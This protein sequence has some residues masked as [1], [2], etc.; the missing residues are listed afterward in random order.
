MVKLALGNVR[1]GSFSVALGARADV[2]FYPERDRNSD[3]L[4]G[5]YVPLTSFRLHQLTRCERVIRPSQTG[6]TPRRWRRSL[7]SIA[8]RGRWAPAASFAIDVVFAN[9]PSRIG[10]DYCLRTGV[11]F[12]VDDTLPVK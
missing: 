3:M 11:G 6:C 1:F 9:L 8:D 4:H 2:R 10:G 12:P 7:A 5:R